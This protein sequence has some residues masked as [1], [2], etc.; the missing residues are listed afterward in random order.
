MG[1]L[2]QAQ[3]KRLASEYGLSSYDA[4]VL[5]AKGRP[6]VAYFETVAKSLGDGK[7]AANRMSDLI[8]PALAERKEE[9][10]AFPINAAKFSD[11]ICKGPAN[12]QD[13]RDV[14]K[15]MLEEGLDL[16]AAK[17]KAGIKEVDE[18]ALR[19]AVKK[20]IADNPKA[21]GEFKNG[22]EAAKNSI[23]GGV[24]K[25]N[26]G[27]PNDLVRRLVDEELAKV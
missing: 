1:E 10:E 24:M 20:V 4:Q 18:S 22:K 23:I 7:T 15:I 25:A 14:F 16:A 27:V 13:R 26:K 9:I 8:Y 19:E 3:R 17:T 11:F 21:V 12:S 5:T 6:T 2:P